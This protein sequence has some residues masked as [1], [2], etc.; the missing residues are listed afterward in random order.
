MLAY[1]SGSAE[2]RVLALLTKGIDR[3]VPL[4]SEAIR[5]WIL[6]RCVDGY[7][8]GSVSDAI[9][10]RHD[11]NEHQG[12]SRSRRSRDI[13]YEMR[14][15]ANSEGW[16]QLVASAR[17]RVISS[18]GDG[19]DVRADSVD[20]ARRILAGVLMELPGDPVQV[21]TN[22]GARAAFALIGMAM[23]DDERGWDSV[24]MSF[25]RVGAELGVE[26]RAASSWVKVLEDRGLVTR[27][28][29]QAF[30]AS[31][32][33]VRKP[34]GKRLKRAQEW[35]GIAVAFGDDAVE[36]VALVL[37][38][39]THPAWTYSDKLGL[40]HWALLL[41]TTANVDPAVFGIKPKVQKRLHAELKSEYEMVPGVVVPYLGEILDRL[42]DDFAYGTKD[43]ATGERITARVAKERA[44]TAYAEQ[45][46]MNKAAAEAATEMKKEGYATVTKLL[47]QFP[48]PRTPFEGKISTRDGRQ[49]ESLAWGEA[50]HRLILDGSPSAEWRQMV[51]RPLTGRLVKARYPRPFAEAVVSYIMS[52]E[53]AVTL[54][55]WLSQ[56]SA[57]DD[58]SMPSRQRR[59]AAQSD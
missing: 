42:A 3:E 30:V 34:S 53:A 13:A 36:P 38:S 14:S 41:A 45:A 56:A 43:K 55:T 47:E 32:F 5:L 11:P 58:P 26:R 24:I 49:R 33:R 8:F 59:P 29:A 2:R 48:I 23:L 21:R 37:R 20:L 15:L 6:S 57:D 19:R 54:D 16:G 40:M 9:G 12:H 46:A 25:A 18:S 31:R 4:P 10:G 44:M 39:V 17:E 35:D 28:R 22:V 50:L 7:M 1:S 52:T 51:A 27:P